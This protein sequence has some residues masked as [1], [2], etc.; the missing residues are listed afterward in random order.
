[1]RLS[2]GRLAAAGLV[3]GLLGVGGAGFAYR[4][5]QLDLAVDHDA[6]RG[7]RTGSQR[8]QLPQH[9]PR[10]QRELVL[11]DVT[12]SPTLP[13]WRELARRGRADQP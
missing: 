13:A 8:W 9:G 3:V 10:Q 12:I 7:W 11:S 1:M 4:A 5:D 2:A 6:E